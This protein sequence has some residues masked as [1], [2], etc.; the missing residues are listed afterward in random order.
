MYRNI[1]VPIDLEDPATAEIGASHAIRLARAFGG[2]L[3][4]LSV[5]PDFGMAMVAQYVPQDYRERVIAE[6]RSRL[7][8]LARDYVPEE[9]HCNEIVGHGRVYDEILRIAGEINSDLIVM[10]AHQ[11]DIRDYLLGPNAARVVRHATRA[12]LVVREPAPYD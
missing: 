2:Q 8:G 10:A 3:N 11:P 7:N 9:I 6:A 5:V 4:L 12:V 1:L